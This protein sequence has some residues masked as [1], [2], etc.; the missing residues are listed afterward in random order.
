MIKEFRRKISSVKTTRGNPPQRRSTETRTTTVR[1]TWMWTRLSASCSTGP[2][3]PLVKVLSSLKQDLQEE[4]TGP[5]VDTELAS[6]IDTLIKDGLPKEKLQDKMNIYHRSENCESLTKVRV[7]QA[8]WD[9]LSPS[10]R[11]QDVRMQKV[12]IVSMYGL[13]GMINKLVEQIP[14]FPVGNELLQEATGA[15]ALFANANTE[16]NRMFHCFWV[17]GSDFVFIGPEYQLG[18]DF[19]Y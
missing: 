8:V 4:K 11:S 19:L 1:K 12:P 5:K 9:N 6:I 16:L 10:V 13:T 18:P 7:N 3:L 14:T 17:I 2:I 15:F